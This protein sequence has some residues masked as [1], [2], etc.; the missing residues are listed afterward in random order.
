MGDYYRL[1][2]DGSYAIQVKKVGYESQTQYIEVN[3]KQHQMEAQRVDFTLQSVS[4]EQIDLRR[5]LRQ[6]MNKV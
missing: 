1:L 6:F 5:M 2:A 4:S 3:N